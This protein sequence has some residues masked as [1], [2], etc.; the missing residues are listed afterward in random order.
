MKNSVYKIFVLA[1]CVVF[2]FS[3]SL[4]SCKKE[5]APEEEVAEEEAAPAEEEEA[6]PAEEEEAEEAPA[7]GTEGLTYWID[8]AGITPSGDLTIYSYK[9]EGVTE[10]EIAQRYAETYPDVKINWV[11]IPGAEFASKI[12]V[13][14]ETNTAAF[15]C[16]WSF[17]AWTT[18]FQSFLADVTDRIPGELKDDILEGIVPA[19][20]VDDVWHGAPLFTGMYGNIYNKD[21]LE[22][23]GY[24]KPPE[25]WDEYFKCAE[26]CTIDEDG[27]GTPEIHGIASGHALGWFGSF[28]FFVVVIKSVGGGFWNYDRDNPQATFN[29]DKG[30][31]ALEILKQHY[32]SSFSDPAMATADEVGLRTA[33]ASGKAAMGLHSIGS[34]EAITAS[35]FPENV[36]KFD[37]TLYP[38][39]PGCDS[40]SINGSMGFSIRNDGN[41]DAA[42]GYVLFYL[43]P[44]M[45]KFM[46]KDYGF[47]TSRNSLVNDEEYVAEFTYVPAAVE[48]AKHGGERYTEENMALMQDLIYPILDNYV[49]G[50]TDAETT[51]SKMEDAFYEAWE[52]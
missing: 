19:T 42:L 20:A 26:A 13:E 48:Q 3:F 38:Y 43:S 52:E 35:D 5:A 28:P 24:E 1:I 47:P 31:R 27:D 23:A 40:Y 45:Q 8:K 51:L 6:A 25:T 36:G 50:V 32:S 49:N 15:D 41:V 30:L 11:S 34:V 14:L 22:Q 9:D 37:Y 29:N 12:A 7:L 21:I 2:V 4:V 16:F 39:D 17:A 10:W 33:I 44:E 18:Q 46:T